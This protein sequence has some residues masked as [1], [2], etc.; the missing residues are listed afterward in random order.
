MNPA[1]A[2]ACSSQDPQVQ[3]LKAM[4]LVEKQQHN[5]T[6]SQLFTCQAEKQHVEQ[7]NTC[8]L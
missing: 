7:E 2:I 3:V 8:S 5:I 1:D 4:L 6:K